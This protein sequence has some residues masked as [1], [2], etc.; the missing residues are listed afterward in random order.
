[1]NQFADAWR[2]NWKSALSVA[3]V[4]VPLSLSLGIASGATPI[5]GIITAIWAGIIAGFLGGSKYNI[6]GP[7]GALSGIL[8]AYA[9]Q[10]S[11]DVLPF[12]AMG[13]GLLSL[14]VWWL[15]W[16]KYLIFVPSSVIHGFTLGV[17]F[18]IGF[19]QLN[20]ALG[21]SGLPVHESLLSNIIESLRHSNQTELGSFLPF[22]IGLGL[23]FFI[24]KKKPLWP[25]SII[26]AILGIIFGYASKTGLIPLDVVTLDDKFPSLA[27]NLFN[28]PS[29]SALWTTGPFVALSTLGKFALLFKLSSIVAFVA[30]LETLIS[31]KVADGMTKTKEKFD[32]SKEVRG[33]ALANIV[34]GLFGGMPASGVF[35]RTA[36]NVKSGADSK[37]SQVINA[38]FVALITFLCLPVFKYIPMSIIAAILV[39]V[40][41]RMVAREHFRKLYEHDTMAFMTA[42]AVALLTVVYDAT[43]GIL[44]GTAAALLFL[45]RKISKAQSYVTCGLRE[46]FNENADNRDTVMVYRFAGEL[47]YVNSRSHTSYLQNLKPVK[48]LV[49]SFRNLF[50]IDIDGGESVEEIIEDLLQKGHNVVVSGI[51]EQVR[52]ILASS[53]WYEKLSTEGRIVETIEE[54]IVKAGA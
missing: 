12:V 3:L 4:S 24:V 52:T 26:V 45:V 39:Y 36:L 41:T 29:I 6:V 16:D 40:A 43:I 28:I 15:R 25:N 10:Y 32:E 17:A 1:M 46:P 44:A 53:H 21:L 11:S 33:V 8:A 22:L 27:L 5:A 35:A 49:L 20:A 13:A 14:I 42:I 30:V 38:L 34:S 7:A 9:L 50:Y 19:G 47:T 2:R 51:H 48:G 31:A 23:M 37:A 54:A 18:T